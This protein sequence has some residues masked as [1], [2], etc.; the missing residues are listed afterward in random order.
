MVSCGNP[1]RSSLVEGKLNPVTK[2]PTSE[3]TGSE[4]S[5]RA[6]AESTTSNPP[7]I[8]EISKIE[9]TN[10]L[11]GMANIPF[12]IGDTDSSLDCKTSLKAK[13]SD[14]RILTASKIQ[15]SGTSP[16]CTSHVLGNQ[17][18]SGDVQ[19]TFIVNDG[20]N[21]SKT[22]FLVTVKHVNQPPELVLSFP[23]VNMNAGASSSAFILNVFD[24]D[25]PDRVCDVANV[26]TL[27]TEGQAGVN[28]IIVSGQWPRCLVTFEPKQSFSGNVS[29]VF[30]V[31]DGVGE[32][33][34]Q[35]F[36]L[37]V[38]A[39]VSPTSVATSTPTPTPID[40]KILE[41]TFSQF[42]LTG[43]GDE[44]RLC[45]ATLKADHNDMFFDRVLVTLKQGEK[46]VGKPDISA[47]YFELI[48]FVDDKN[49][50]IIVDKVPVSKV[51]YNCAYARFQRTAGVEYSVAMAD[52]DFYSDAEAKV[53]LCTLP[54]GLYRKGSIFETVKLVSSTNSTYISE[55][56][57]NDP[58]AGC[59]TNGPVYNKKIFTG[60]PD[61]TFNGMGY[62]LRPILDVIVKK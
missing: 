62:Q 20:K 44:G 33:T 26:F 60:F 29:G 37:S 51:D 3:K 1:K 30:W 41:A 31:S 48:K 19:L 46:Y 36:L 55:V 28:R 11:S 18:E 57:L 24:K 38:P 5:L 47:E 49:N 43:I 61:F 10:I 52:L 8:S 13:S 45:V 53:K 9:M 6:G 2:A 15:F 14:E 16:N 4:E 50:F 27:V 40:P 34:R 25:G 54:R 17:N 22:D 59:V 35:R 12:T 42:A 7:T 32:S 21:E 58:L 56:K 23:V 39:Q